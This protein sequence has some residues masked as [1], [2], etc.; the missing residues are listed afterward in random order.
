M[1]LNL[2]I[3]HLGQFFPN[4]FF[5]AMSDD[6]TFQIYQWEDLEAEILKQKNKT[7]N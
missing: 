3:G 4:G 2:P 6:K 1:A 5:V 7:T